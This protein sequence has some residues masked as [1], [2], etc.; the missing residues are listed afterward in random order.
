MKKL[1]GSQWLLARL[2]WW[3]IMLFAPVP[4]LGYWFSHLVNDGVGYNLSLAAT[5]G[6][7]WLFV[8]VA[9]AADACATMQATNSWVVGKRLH[10]IAL[11]VS[12][13]VCIAFAALQ[14]IG[15]P[16]EELPDWFHNIIYVPV[17]LYGLIS[18]S[19]FM[20][21]RHVPRGRRLAFL[22]CLVGWVI[23]LLLDIYFGLLGQKD[24]LIRHHFQF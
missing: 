9:L 15:R 1:Y 16:L 23:V 14:L 2:P 18:V 12:V 22:A 4:W 24:W 19:P 20:L 13:V 7:F 17:F 11:V 10:Q 6:D 8:A 5:A 21:S 3:V